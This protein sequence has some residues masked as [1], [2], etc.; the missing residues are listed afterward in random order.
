M[1]K[2][3]GKKTKANINYPKKEKKRRNQPVT[4]TAFFG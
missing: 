4:S 3:T 1:Q 2:V